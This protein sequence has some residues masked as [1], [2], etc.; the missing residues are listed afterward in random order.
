MTEAEC[1]FVDDDDD[2]SRQT[3]TIKQNK[4]HPN[5]TVVITSL[6]DPGYVTVQLEN[7]DTPVTKAHRRC[8]K[9]YF[10]VVGYIRRKHKMASSSSQKRPE[11]S[12]KETSVI[13]AAESM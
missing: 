2:D 1:R 13:P 10:L 9:G 6:S 11:K 12:D 8:S 4:P 5:K 7:L 3:T